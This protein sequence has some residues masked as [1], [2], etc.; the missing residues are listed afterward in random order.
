VQRGGPRR[1]HAGRTCSL[2]DEPSFQVDV[3]LDEEILRK[4]LY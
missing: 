3:E 1:R 2:G 4:R